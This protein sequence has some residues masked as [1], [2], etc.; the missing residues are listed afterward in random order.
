MDEQGH[1]TAGP[2]G[3]R[4]EKGR[5]QVLT[6]A[7]LVGLLLLLVFAYDS[8]D[9][10]DRQNEE[11]RRSWAILHK[12]EEVLSSAKDAEADL[13]G[14]LITNNIT[15]LDS[16]D[17]AVKAL[18]ED[19]TTLGSLLPNGRVQQEYAEMCIASDSLVASMDT[20]IRQQQLALVPVGEP[21][22]VWF[23]K[24]RKHMLKVR[25][26]YAL[27]L[28]RNGLALSKGA[29]KERSLA[30]I[31]P[32]VFLAFSVL[33]L[34]G[35]TLLFL[36]MVH[37]LDRSRRAEA[38][39][40]QLLVQRDQEAI[41]RERTE[42]Q[43]Q[44]VVDA[45]RSGIM[46]LRAV[47]ND[48]GAIEDLEVNLVNK[49]AA[50]AFGTEA[51]TLVG[52][53]LSKAL[54]EVKR[55]GLIE[56][57]SEVIEGDS[58]SNS[59]LQLDLG[60]GPRWYEFKAVRLLDGLVVNFRPRIKEGVAEGVDD[61]GPGAHGMGR[62]ARV[63]AHEIRNPL[64]NINLAVDQ[65]EQD[66]PEDLRH[67][68]GVYTGIL[69]RNAERIEEHITQILNSS[70]TMHVVLT[71][72]DVREVLEAVVGQVRDR[73]EL[74]EMAIE[75]D[76]EAALPKVAMDPQT[77]SL[78]LTNLCVNAIEAMEPGMGSLQLR[79]RSRGN[80]VQVEVQD[81]G[82]GLTPEE[83]ERIFQPF[84]SKRKGGLGLGLT[85]ARNILDAHGA[86][87]SVRSRKGEGT[88]FTIGFPTS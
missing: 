4:R 12:A 86:G 39:A 73:A 41:I 38:A 82:R 58:A 32:M 37:H 15:F 48:K 21:D 77:L 88:T 34:S 56:L 40:Q 29:D 87:I 42:K 72:G 50:E 14:Y 6:V 54:P 62:F 45:S 24:S 80:T 51:D 23:Q 9:E 46:S 10:L 71:P 36:R 31:T 61:G 8:L 3:I 7:G 44:R 16:Y 74:L 57:W 5:A 84:F 83:Q 75:L 59:E 43:L 81:N 64:T 69:R 55:S 17:A 60:A 68:T 78:A 70:R 47:R 30:R 27:I 63:L 52:E 33:S 25:R 20:L 1:G 79:A 67:G 19:L 66:I 22:R 2:S 11:I 65:L 28:A 53:R 76:T 35:L 18:R 85:E 13:R 49:L 26:G